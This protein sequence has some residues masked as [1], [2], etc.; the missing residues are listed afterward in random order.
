MLSPHSIDT[1]LSVLLGLS[2]GSTMKLLLSL[3]YHD[4]NIFNLKYSD[5]KLLSEKWCSESIKLMNYY[6][7]KFEC[8]GNNVSKQQR[9]GYPVCKMVNHIWISDKYKNV[10]NS[11]NDDNTTTTSNDNN[12]KKNGSN[13]KSLVS[14][15]IDK[16]VSYIDFDDCKRAAQE[17]DN[18]M[19]NSSS[20]KICNMIQESMIDSKCKILITNGVYFKGKFRNHFNSKETKLRYFYG[21]C[22]RKKKVVKCVMMR[23]YSC[24]QFYCKNFDGFEIVKLMYKQC[25][26]GLILAR[27]RSENENGNENAKKNNNNNDTN[28]NNSNDNNARLTC[29]EIPSIN[30]QYKYICLRLPKFKFRSTLCLDNELQSRNVGLSNIYNSNKCKLNN[31]F[32][33]KNNNIDDNLCITHIFHRSMFEIDESGLEPYEISHASAST[34]T[35]SSQESQSQSQSQASSFGS[36]HSDISINNQLMAGIRHLPR[37]SFDHPFNFYVY[38]YSRGSVLFTGRVVCPRKGRK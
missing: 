19:Y 33:N 1:G 28:K 8:N 12:K 22:T 34:S 13:S 21:D 3:M 9:N 31:I 10:L 18:F 17:M 23:N 15:L 6:N 35:T 26:I 16:E 24:K 38:D 7:E 2:E 32:D 14:E 29:E 5:I 25:N 4:L 37:V 11:N 20:F 30:F 36:Y 27:K